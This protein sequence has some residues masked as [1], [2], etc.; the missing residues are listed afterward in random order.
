MP[1]LA[2]AFL[3]SLQDTGCIDNDEI[4]GT[5]WQAQ[6]LLL[7][8]GDGVLQAACPL[9]V[10]QHSY[11]EFVFDW[12]WANAYGEHG[13]AYYPKLLSAVPFTPVPG[14]RLIARDDAARAALAKAMTQLTEQSGA[15]SCHVLFADAASVDALQTQGWMKRLN[16]QFHW[17]NRSYADFEGFLASLAQDKRKKIRAEQRK[18]REA[19]VTYEWRDGHTATAADWKFFYRCYATTYQLHH[20]T[21]YLTPTFFQTYAKAAPDN[22]LL[23]LA[24]VDGEPVAASYFV[25]S[26]T[27]LFGRYWGAVRHIPCLHFDACYYQPIAQAIALGLNVFEGGAQGEHKMA[28]GLA[29]VAT[30]SMHWLAHPAFADA[31][32]R[33]L[34]RESGGIEAYLDELNERRV[35]K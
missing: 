16:V 27:R 28:R 4:T 18:V 23:L 3:C 35:Y 17:T 21:P 2:S 19:G 6:Y 22:V 20:S 13:L 24:W 1:F 5:G 11:G 25:R 30:T 34:Q 12:A 26:Q 31:V 10:K 32:E 7:W 9:Y 15:S 8:S 33:Y 29:P 14:P